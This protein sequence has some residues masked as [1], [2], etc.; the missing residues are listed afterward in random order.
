MNCLLVTLAKW[1]EI[2]VYDLETLL[3]FNMR[4]DALCAWVYEPGA[5]GIYLYALLFFDM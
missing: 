1:T 5:E 3:N 4:F 2:R